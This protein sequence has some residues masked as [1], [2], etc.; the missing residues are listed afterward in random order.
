MRKGITIGREQVLVMAMGNR[1][2]EKI[3]FSQI[4]L[5]AADDH[6]PVGIADLFHDHPNGV[7]AVEPQRSGK[8]IR[9]VIER[10]G[11]CQDFFLRACRHGA[12][13]RGV[14][15]STAETVLAVTPA[16]SAT[17][18]RVG[19][20]RLPSARILRDFIALHSL[21]SSPGAH[22]G[23][24]FYLKSGHATHAPEESACAGLP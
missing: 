8:E 9:A 4:T 10:T 5:Y 11:R 20:E 17:D 14:C 6:G 19:V 21:H 22:T 24:G 2:K 12:R 18:R 3:L 16:R 13:R 7:C 1:E 15:F 23:M